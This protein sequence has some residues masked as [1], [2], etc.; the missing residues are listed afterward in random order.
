LRYG[1]AFSVVKPKRHNWL[2]TLN[3]LQQ[4]RSLIGRQDLVDLLLEINV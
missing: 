3:G 2:A 4:E 1:K